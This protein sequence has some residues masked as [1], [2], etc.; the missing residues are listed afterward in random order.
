MQSSASSKPH[1]IATIKVVGIVILSRDVIES[2]ISALNAATVIF[3]PALTH[4]LALTCATGTE[5]WD[6]GSH[7]TGGAHPE[8]RVGRAVGSLGLSH[9]EMQAVRSD[10][11]RS[12]LG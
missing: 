7:D 10:N 2:D 1:L 6:Q 11:A 4:E 12:L 3:S 9:D 5:T 8:N